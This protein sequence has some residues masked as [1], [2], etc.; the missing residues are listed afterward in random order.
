M[1]AV[2]YEKRSLTRCFDYCDL[3]KF[4]IL[5]KWSLWTDGHL[6]EVSTIAEVI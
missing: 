2:V 1:V 6:R 5:K 4:G 3:K